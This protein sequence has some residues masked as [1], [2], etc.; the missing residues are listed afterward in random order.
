LALVNR[1][2][3]GEVSE[4]PVSV[5]K[6]LVKNSLDVGTSDIVAEMERGG[7]DC[8]LIGMESCCLADYSNDWRFEKL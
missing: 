4:R 7:I 1:I 2:A 5:V 6:E 3:A 8:V